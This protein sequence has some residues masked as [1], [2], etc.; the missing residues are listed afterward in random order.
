MSKEIAWAEWNP[1]MVCPA[2]FAAKQPEIMGKFSG[3][4]YCYAAPGMPHTPEERLR[5][6]QQELSTAQA[7]NLLDRL[8]DRHI[9]RL[10]FLGGEPQSRK[11]FAALVAHAVEKFELVSVTTNGMGTKKNQEALMTASVVEVS[12]DSHDFAIASQTRPPAVVK[13]ALDTIDTLKDHPFLCLS[14]VV[15]PESLAQLPEFINWAFKN[16][17]IKR[18]NLYPLLGSS[19]VPD[20]LVLSPNQAQ[21][22][23]TDL[24]SQYP[25]YGERVC[26][27][28]QHVVVNH[29]G[30]VLPCAAFLGGTMDSE[31]TW[32]TIGQFAGHDF[33]PLAPVDKLEPPGC[34]GKKLYD[35]GWSREVIKTGEVKPAV[36]NGNYCM[37]CNFPHHAEN[38]NCRHCGFDHFDRT[39]ILMMCSAFTVYN[40]EFFPQAGII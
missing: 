10:S 11:D 13:S 39:N 40:P 9:P 33:S 18:I 14:S 15:T 21:N 20:R 7:L 4:T 16:K 34:P 24:E 22:L 17:G 29:D 28:G 38:G 8:A 3:C 36:Q 12:L 26:K 2:A 30:S 19:E 32:K 6:S 35:S 23:L 25:T 27:A 31:T 1:T 5:F 37:R